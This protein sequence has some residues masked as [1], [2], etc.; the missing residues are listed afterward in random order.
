MN[1][2]ADRSAVKAHQDARRLM[3][4]SRVEGI[5]AAERRWLDAHL[6]ACA[7]CAREASELAAAIDALRAAPAVA[8]SDMV[9]RTRQAV[10]RR[11]EGRRTEEARTLPLW[12]ALITSA[13]S[14][15]LT[16][17]YIWGAF[18]SLGQAAGVPEPLW[19]A[20]F[21]TW[22]FLP[23]TVVTAILAWRHAG[24]GGRR[25]HWDAQLHRGQL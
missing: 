4:A 23:A 13:A 16:T 3:A 9:R 19:Q 1:Q 6:D 11:A 2:D 12:V 21:L 17:P 15:L 8:S 25:S 24:E 7:D 14:M 5:A 20:G 10:R 22:W 18:A